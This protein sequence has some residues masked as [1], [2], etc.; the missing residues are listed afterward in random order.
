MPMPALDAHYWTAAEVRAL[1]D[2]GKRYECV[3]GELLVTPSPG[4]PHQFVVKE[5]LLALDPYVR[6]LGLGRLCFAPADVE[7]EASTL[8]QPDL[9]VARTDGAPLRN[10]ADIRGLLLAVEVLAPSTARYDRGVKRR[11]YQRNDV[12]E[13]WVV[14]SDARLVERWGAQDE[15]PEVCIERLEWRP[16]D[17]VPPL[18]LDLVA[19]FA[20]ALD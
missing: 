11:F 6:E 12:A 16:A 14:D 9:F 19:L 4:Y 17:S 8:V 10:A 13:Y 15:H 5:L 2:D 3:D 7:L 1:P 20:R 18:R